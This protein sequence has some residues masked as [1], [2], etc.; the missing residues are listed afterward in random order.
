MNNSI[1]IKKVHSER[2]PIFESSPTEFNLMLEGL[3]ARHC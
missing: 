3:D 2:A 1:I